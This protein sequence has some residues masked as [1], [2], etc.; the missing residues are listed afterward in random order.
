[1]YEGTALDGDFHS[2]GILYVRVIISRPV[3][4]PSEASDDA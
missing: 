2:G 1:M 4:H 3:Q